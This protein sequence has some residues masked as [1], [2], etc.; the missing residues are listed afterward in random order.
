VLSENKQN[1]LVR[2]NNTIKNNLKNWL[3]GVRMIND[4]IDILDAHI[5]NIGI[6]FEIVIEPSAN[7]FAALRKASIAVENEFK[8][9]K[10]IGEPIITTDYFRALKDVE[11]ILDVTKI[12]V[13]NKFG[14]PYSEVVYS[15]DDNTTLDGRVILAPKNHIF[16]LKFPDIDIKGTVR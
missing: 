8:I 15:I 10:E 13:V 7:R 1:H 9:H 3:N 14:L 5:I 12:K 4:S 6:E 11:E 2:T 16:E